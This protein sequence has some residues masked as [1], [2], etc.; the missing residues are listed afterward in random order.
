MVTRLSLGSMSTVVLQVADIEELWYMVSIEE[1][2]PTTDPNI[3]LRTSVDMINSLILVLISSYYLPI[4]VKKGVTKCEYEQRLTLDKV[5]LYDLPH[6]CSP[7]TMPSYQYLY[8]SAVAI[9][10]AI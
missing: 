10:A 3:T 9:I 4:V 6:Q 7:G 8:N 1:S 5:A 2:W